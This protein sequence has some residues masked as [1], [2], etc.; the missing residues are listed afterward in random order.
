ML[1]KYTSFSKRYTCLPDKSD[2]TL[3]W[4]SLLLAGKT[5]IEKSLIPDNP[6]PNPSPHSKQKPARR[7]SYGFCDLKKWCHQPHMKL[8]ES[9]GNL[10][11]MVW[12]LRSYRVG[13]ELRC[14]SKFPNL[15][16]VCLSSRSL[17][18]DYEA[19]P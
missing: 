5:W 10:F 8:R 18:V 12:F 17:F 14:F 7:W 15:L 4:N 1:N 6:S 9:G 16:I 11:I 13:N 2:N 19:T 3:P